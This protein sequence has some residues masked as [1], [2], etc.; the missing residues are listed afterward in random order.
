MDDL[1][2]HEGDNKGPAAEAEAIFAEFDKDESGSLKYEE[3]LE[4]IKKH[5]DVMEGKKQMTKEE[6]AEKF[7][8]GIAMDDLV[9]HEGDKKGPAAAAKAIFAEFDKD[10]SG[11]LKYEE[12]IEVIK[13]HPDVME[14]E[15]QMTKEEF[16]EKFP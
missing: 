8:E 9:E 10:E 1:V 16:A 14:G 2:E 13:K 3:Y 6:F 15:K 5:P 4:V 11:S 7:P 12:Y